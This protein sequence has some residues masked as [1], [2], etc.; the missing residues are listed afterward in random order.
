[1]TAQGQYSTLP[2]AAGTGPRQ[3]T[4][5]PNNTLWVTLDAAEKVA[6]VTGVTPTPVPIATP[7]LNTRIS[8]AP[9]KRV[10]ASK[11]R[12]KVK[13]RFTGTRGASFQCRLGKRPLKK[14]R[15]CSSPKVVKVKPGRY[16]FRVRATLA[17][18]V[19]PT[20]AKTRFRVVRRR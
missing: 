5:G 19:D 10:R 13:V 7:T 9:A 6:R 15:V 20:P 4:A 11:N 14:W 18:S 17:G 12:T 16:V 1:M 2:I 8:K 3:L